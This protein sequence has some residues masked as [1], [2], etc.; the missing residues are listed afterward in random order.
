METRSSMVSRKERRSRAGCDRGK[1]TISNDSDSRRSMATHRMRTK[2]LEILGKSWPVR[3]W[4]GRKCKP[5]GIEVHKAGAAVELRKGSRAVLLSPK[6]AFF[7]PEVCQNFDAYA[8][9]LPAE[10][11][12]GLTTVDFSADPAAF[13]LC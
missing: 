1:T 4:A 12:N 11:K 3:V 13:N 9:A 10:E 5:F 8:Y 7:A 6:H 2:P